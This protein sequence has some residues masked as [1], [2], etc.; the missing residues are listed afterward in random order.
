VRE[1]EEH[2]HTNH[3]TTDMIVDVVSR[4]KDTVGK[5]W[6]WHLL[7][8]LKNWKWKGLGEPFQ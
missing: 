2:D 6:E 3:S 8:T 1:A 5:G 4:A 7:D